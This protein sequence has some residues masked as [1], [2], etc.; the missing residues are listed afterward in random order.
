MNG[1][2]VRYIK[3]GDCIEYEV[4]ACEIVP[5]P[6]GDIAKWRTPNGRTAYKTV[7]QAHRGA[8]Q[9]V[10]EGLMWKKPA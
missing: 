2:C 6:K 3:A 5:A 1:Y 9:T 4:L 8:S 10:G 7:K